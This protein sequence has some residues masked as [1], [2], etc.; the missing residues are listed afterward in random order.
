MSQHAQTKDERFMVQLYREAMKK[1]QPDEACDR[2]IV[3]Q[4]VGLQATAVDTICVLLGKANFIRKLGEHD[5][6]LSSN[7]LR[8]VE[9]LL[10]T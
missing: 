4:L 3:G 1:G 5:V 2:Y 10:D 6:A 8:L 7:G 9:N